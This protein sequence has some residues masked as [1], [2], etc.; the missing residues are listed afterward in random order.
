MIPDVPVTEEEEEEV[1]ISTD[2]EEEE[3]ALKSH[4]RS[5]RKEKYVGYR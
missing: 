4:L 1:E 2:V 3:K 5:I